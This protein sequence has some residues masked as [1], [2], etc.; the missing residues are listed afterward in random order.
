MTSRHRRYEKASDALQVAKAAFAVEIGK[1]FPVGTRVHLEWGHHSL[2]PY[3]V[4]SM[5]DS[6]KRLYVRNLITG[7]EW[8]VS[9]GLAR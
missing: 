1:I 8:W 2:G 7:K 6:G 3:Q 4:L 5:D 9:T